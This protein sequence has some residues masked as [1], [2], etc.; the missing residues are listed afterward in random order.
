M[1]RKQAFEKLQI[2]CERLD[3]INTTKLF[4]IPVRLYL[5]GSLLTNKPNPA[6]IDLL[7]EFKYKDINNV[8]YRISYDKTLPET[9]V[10]KYLKNRMR[11]IHIEFL[12]L[13]NSSLNEWLSD[14]CMPLNTSM[15]EIWNENLNWREA[16]A[17]AE[18][19]PICYDAE[20]EYHQKYLQKKLKTIIENKGEQAARD[21][22]EKYSRNIRINIK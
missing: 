15:K 4:I 3:E 12:E 6:D 14:H 8:L 19:S 7:L 21:W 17:E 5:F 11:N 9:H 20:L 1:K 22:F 18:N 13:T 2:I 16:L 10:A